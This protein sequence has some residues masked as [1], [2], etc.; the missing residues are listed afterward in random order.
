[1]QLN[2]SLGGYGGLLIAVVAAVGATLAVAYY[3]KKE[4]KPS[5]SSR[6]E[7]PPPPRMPK[8]PVALNPIEKIPFKLLKKKSVSHD[9]R[10]FTF[11]LQSKKHVLGLPVGNHMYISANIGGKIESRPYTP[12]TS[13]DELGYFELVIKVY[14]KNVHPKFP[15]GGK[16]SQHLDM[17]AIGDTIDVRGPSGKVVYLGRG[18]I[19]V[20]FPGKPEQIRKAKEIGLIS[21]GTGITPMLQIIMAVVKDQA[22]DTK[23]SLLFANQTEED[24]LLREELEKLAKEHKNFNIWYTLD[25]PGEG[26]AYSS[27]FINSDMI[28]SHLPAP[29]PDTQILMCGPPP[30]IK[31]ACIPSLEK[32]E[33]AEDMYVAF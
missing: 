20:K 14:A 24:I 11:A 26:W 1:M 30:M 23:V 7:G 12:I 10:K 32:L 8:G 2:E 4:A 15:W 3:W 18:Y 25:R 5:T 31:F 9:T 19:R 21:G 33:Y 22:D 29:G 27:G 17:L 16:M 28:R 13:D 6:G